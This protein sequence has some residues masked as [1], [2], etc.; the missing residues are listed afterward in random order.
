MKNKIHFGFL[1]PAIILTSLFIL[2]F[3]VYDINI[4]VDTLT[5]LGFFDWNMFLHDILALCVII[6]MI[7]YSLVWGIIFKRIRKYFLS[8]YS[9]S[10]LIPICFFIITFAP[11]L[12][13]IIIFM[14]II[15]LY[16]NAFF[17]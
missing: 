14:G 3:L 13:W 15:L 17:F 4:F 11:I 16:L 2:L 1:I 7:S 8:I 9:F 10:I 6:A 12:E 5:S